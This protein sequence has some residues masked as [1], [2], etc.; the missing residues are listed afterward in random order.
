MASAILAVIRA[1]ESRSSMTN[2]AGAIM[3]ASSP[4]PST[5]KMK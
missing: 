5:I 4:A 3:L 1:G 2:L